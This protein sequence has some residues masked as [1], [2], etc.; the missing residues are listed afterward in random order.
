MYNKEN[1][2]NDII[3]EWSMK[4]AVIDVNNMYHRQVL[5]EILDSKNIPMEAISIIMDN[6]LDE[7]GSLTSI[8]TSVADSRGKIHSTG[9]SVEPIIDPYQNQN[10]LPI[11]D[12]EEDEEQLEDDGQTTTIETYKFDE[13]RMGI[14]ETGNS[15]LITE[16]I[17]E[18]KFKCFMNGDVYYETNNNELV[19][20]QTYVDIIENKKLA[21]NEI[22]DTQ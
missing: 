21:V 6:L 2:I 9:S 10:V 13:K 14:F 20:E 7:S 15:V 18:N 1:I 19:K 4:V 8:T 3:N 22:T 11:Q 5:R 17:T 16:V 12:D